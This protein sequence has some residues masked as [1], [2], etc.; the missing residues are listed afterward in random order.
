MADNDKGPGYPLL[1]VGIAIG[2]AMD[3]VGAGIAIGVALG[4]AFGMGSR[5]T[6]SGGNGQDGEK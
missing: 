5:R 2:M 3:N 4:V 1:P 6:R